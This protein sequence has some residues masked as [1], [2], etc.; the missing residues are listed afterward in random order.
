ME[1]AASGNPFLDKFEAFFN[2]YYKKDIQRLAQ[3]YPQNRTLEVNFKDLEF[4]DYELADELILNPDFIL[5]AAHEAVTKIDIPSVDAKEFKPHTRFFNLPI[6]R[7]ILIKN[8]GAEHLGKLMS[9]DGI[10]RQTTEVLPKLTEALWQC[11]RCGNTYRKKQD[12]NELKTP[13]ICE[14][15]HKDFELVPDKS[16]FINY[17]KIQIQ[18]PLESLKGGEQSAYLDVYVTDD[19]VNLLNA[20]DRIVNTGILRLRKPKNKSVI[21]GRYLESLHIERTEREFEDI[22]ITPEEEEEIKELSANEKI[23]EMLVESIAPGIYG[24]ETVKEAIALQ[25]FGGIKKFMPDESKVRGNIH[26]LLIGDPGTG[27]SQLLQYADR[28]APKSTYVTGKTSSG[29]GLTASA[30][31]DEFGEGGWTLKAGALVLAS[32]GMAMIDEFDK[33]STEDRSA[34]HEAM[35]QQTVSIAKAGIVTRF[36]TDTTILAAANPKF[37]RFDPYSM[38]LEQIDLPPTLMSRFDLFFVI[39]DVLDLKK[40]EEIARHILKTHKTG[41]MLRQFKISRD[42]ISKDDEE[43]QKKAEPKIMPK[44]LRKYIS[45]ARQNVFPI[46]T[47]DAMDTIVKFYLSLR[48]KSKEG[49]VTVTARQ[50]EGLVRLSEASARIKLKKSVDVDDAD[51]AIRLYKTSMQDVGVDP[52]TGKMDIDIITSGQPHSQVEGM[53][54]ILAIIKQKADEVDKVPVEEIISEAANFGIDKDKVQEFITKLKK[55]GEIYE[56]RTGFIKPTQKE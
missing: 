14:C 5:E 50:L 21:Y 16:E 25:M 3:S 11:R 28:I 35:E 42:A 10:V 29:A 1:E 52:K 24:Y 37:S 32:G 30:E 54:K 19:L 45:Y 43:E 6:D 48:S 39:K 44:L 34:M 9:V 4:F 46:M 49:S 51:R 40:D 7:K 15:K 13:P 23:F 17:Q 33:M 27:K 41:E 36:Q 18:E 26:I 53:R 22:I 56:P 2:E 20:G 38:A 31:K 55:T 8:I 12:D 47:Q